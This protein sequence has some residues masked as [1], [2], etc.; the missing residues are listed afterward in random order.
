MRL[1]T[2]V[3]CPN[4]T[5][6]P[7][8]LIIMPASRLIYAAARD[9]FLPSIFAKLHPKRRTP[10][11]AMALQAGLTVFFIVFGGGFRSE[12][13]VDRSQEPQL[14]RTPALLNFFSVTSWTFY[15]LTVLGLLVLRVKE[16]NLERPY[17]TWIITPIIFCGVSFPLRPYGLKT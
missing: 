1:S 6:N 17:R 3:G 15:L 9:H 16:P 2:P 7:L 14:N 13:Q 11:H 10:D 4:E 5:S 8:K 12:F